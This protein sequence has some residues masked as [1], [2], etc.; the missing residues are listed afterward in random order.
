MRILGKFKGTKGVIL[1]CIM[2]LLIV[3][4]YYYLSNKSVPSVDENMDVTALTKSEVALMRNLDVNYP[5]S[6]REVVKYFSE[7][8]ECFY[9][10]EHTSEEIEALANQI[11]SIYD[12]E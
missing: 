7:I 9:N 5:Q 10:E 6:P 8:T 12:D 11:R 3:G 4:Y 1:L 2:A